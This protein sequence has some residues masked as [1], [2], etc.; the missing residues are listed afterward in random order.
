M[1]THDYDQLFEK[2]VELMRAKRPQEAFPLLV[3]YLK[4]NPDSEEGW[5]LLSYAVQS[6]SK[7]VESVQRVLKINPDNQHARARLKRLTS[8]PAEKKKRRLVPWVVIALLAGLGLALVGLIG[9]RYRSFL[10]G[11]NPLA[12]LGS[13]VSMATEAPGLAVPTTV[14][15]TPTRRLTLT[16]T[17]SQEPSATPVTGTAMAAT[18]SPDS[19][20]ASSPTASPTSAPTSPPSPIPTMTPASG[21]IDESVAEQMD[22]I[23]AQVAE[24][25][26]LERMGP[27]NRSMIAEED[28]RSLLE[29][30]YLERNSKEI[31]ADQVIVLS[32]LGLVEPTYDLYTKTL[33]QIGEGIGGFYL[34][35][36]DELY[37][38]GSTFTGLERYIFAHEYTHA[39]VDQHY[40]LDEIGV[41]PECLS[42]TDRCLA[43]SA[44]IEG[45]ATYLMNQWLLAHGTE[46]DLA[47]IAAVQYAPLE[48]AISSSNLPPPYLVRELNFKYGDGYAFVEYF[49]DKWD[50]QAINL[51]YEDLPWTSEQIFHPKK[52]QVKEKPKAVIEPPLQDIL[53]DD[54]R[55]LTSDRL[56]ELGTQMVLAHGIDHLAQLDSAVAAEAAAGWGGDRY[57]VYYRGST[58]SSILVADWVWDHRREADEF[59]EA[60]QQH[61]NLSYRGN[62]VE[63]E[64]GLCWQLL[65]DHVACIFQADDETLWIRAPELET[66]DL[67]RQE[68]PPFETAP[69][70]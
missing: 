40:A 62:S 61:L 23:E 19:D 60:M 29:S 35:W 18:A 68:Y 11:L 2:A 1:D 36:E 57:R 37:V 7:K 34:P 27:V 53:G 49:I 32:A 13:Q 39:L 52:Y 66:V 17:P 5:Y 24:L 16:V 70:E 14:I 43:I 4:A 44:L 65:N 51:I 15:P 54:W 28:V 33:N 12:R 48:Q 50:W 20:S 55:M 38:I 64:A 21:V 63:H 8:K 30:I 46:S 26:D 6:H 56:G 59:F 58:R 42:D 67:I 47:D 3:K 41:Y 9:W 22:V 25:R 10:F 31:I 45:D 69:S